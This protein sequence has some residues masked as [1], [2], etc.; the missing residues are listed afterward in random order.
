M[1][2][3]RRIYLQVFVGCLLLS[4]VSFLYCLYE[5]QRQ[6]LQSVNQYEWNDFNNSVKAFKNKVGESKIDLE[7]MEQKIVDLLAVNGFRYIFG[8]KGALYRDGEELFNTSP[9]EFDYQIIMDLRRS[10]ILRQDSAAKP[11]PQEVSGRKLLIF[12]AAEQMKQGDSYLL[13]YYK[14]VTDIFVRTRRLFFQGFLF[15]LILLGIIGYVLYRG[16]FRAVHPLW[17]LKQAAASIEKGNF[18]TQV[19]VRTKDEIGELTVSFN[20]MAKKVDEHIEKLN[21]TNEAQKRL[22][23]SLSHELKTPLTAIMGY[24][25]MLLTVRLDEEQRS[26]ALEYIRSESRRLSRLSVK[27]ME[28]SGLYGAEAHILMQETHMEELFT[29]LRSLTLYRLEEKKLRLETMCSPEGLTAW[30]DEDLMMSLLMNLV[31]NACKASAIG[32]VITVSA[33]EGGICVADTGTGIPR[34]E[35]DRVTEAFYMVDKSRSRSAGSIGLGLAFCEQI[36]QIHK[37]RLQIE[38]EVGHGTRVSVLW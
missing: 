1:K 17:E 29:R 25:D 26:R 10:G 13:V 19:P 7:Y 6:N 16:I 5:S 2:L 18:K 30:I 14:D 9:Y 37:A 24:S 3:F 21:Q 33:D 27:M 38:S 28:L 34:E 23:G 20:Q 22:I 8:S 4:Q 11:V 32:G 35:L 15:S 36:A 31:D 12:C